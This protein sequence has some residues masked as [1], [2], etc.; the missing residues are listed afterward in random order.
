MTR[1]RAD[2][3]VKLQG[4]DSDHAKSVAQASLSALK[5]LILSDKKLPGKKSLYIRLGCRGD[6][7]NIKPP[8]WDPSNEAESIS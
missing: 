1:K 5:Q 6:W 8:G 4:W 2:V 3:V 7:P